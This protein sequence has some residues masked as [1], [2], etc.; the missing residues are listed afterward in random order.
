M[1]LTFEKA[2]QLREVNI[3][4]KD[5]IE[6]IG[7]TK[8]VADIIL[9]ILEG[10][11]ADKESELGKFSIEGF[12]KNFSKGKETCSINGIRGKSASFRKVGDIIQKILSDEKD[13]NAKKYFNDKINTRLKNLLGNEMFE[14]VDNFTLE[15]EE[16]PN[17]T[18]S[19]RLILKFKETI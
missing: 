10:I 15:K 13:T 5:V 7:S 14:V 18:I 6:E 11:V 3:K 8:Y 12:I 19:Y 16:N 4:M 1:E 17:N 2:K 9:D